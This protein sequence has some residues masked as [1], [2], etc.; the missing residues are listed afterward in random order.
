MKI[1]NVYLTNA[2]EETACLMVCGMTVGNRQPFPKEKRETSI[3][4]GSLPAEIK[5]EIER[6]IFSGI[7]HGITEDG[8]FDFHPSPT[9]IS[10]KQTLIQALMVNQLG[11]IRAE[12]IVDGLIRRER[13]LL[14][15]D[16]GF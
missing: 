6:M 9:D 10:D 1:V 2:H 14:G 3:R 12:R 7:V 8:K 11:F 13:I 4:R 15:A 5:N 16:Q